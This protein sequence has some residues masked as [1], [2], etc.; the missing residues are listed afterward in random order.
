MPSRAVSLTAL[1]GIPLIHPGDDLAAILAAAIR[2]QGI[3]PAAGDIVVVAQ[4][5]VSKAEGRYVDLASVTPSPKA[6]ELAA[7]TGKDPRHVE[8]ILSESTE[9]VRQREGLVIVAHRLGLV[10]ANAGV[11]QSN[12]D[13]ATKEERVLLLPAD[14]DASAA[15]LRRALEAAFGVTMAVVISDSFG[16]AWRNGVVGV[17]IG[18]AGLP[19][20]ID[21]RGRADLA[22]RPLRV[23][24]IGYAD[25][26]A[27]A[28]ALVMG[29]ADER[30]PAVLIHG[31]AQDSPVGRAADLVRPKHMDLFR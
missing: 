5:V 2:R 7:K 28:A 3:V 20:L 30:I 27:S 21:A 22:G 29:E 1:E 17:A 18:A 4:K 26:V 9:I 10:M 6:I 16:R 8:V 11:D 25:E 19:A 31:L 24:E 23:T 15:T 13:P 12:L 14:P